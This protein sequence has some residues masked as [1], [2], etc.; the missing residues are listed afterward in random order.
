MRENNNRT[1]RDEALLWLIGS[2][3]VTKIWIFN[4][5][6]L[7]DSVHLLFIFYYRIFLNLGFWGGQKEA[8]TGV[9]PLGYGTSR[10]FMFFGPHMEFNWP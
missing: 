7:F 3:L 2:F 6:D 4:S 5:I 10:Q 8:R 9:F 1:D